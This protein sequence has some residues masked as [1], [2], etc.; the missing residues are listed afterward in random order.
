MQ[1]VLC[2]GF[3]EGSGVPTALPAMGLQILRISKVVEAKAHCVQ[4]SIGS[5]SLALSNGEK[6]G[7]HTLISASRNL[8]I[9]FCVYM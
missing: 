6:R 7:T 4:T 2:E 9:L 3:R 5:S 1:N 8:T